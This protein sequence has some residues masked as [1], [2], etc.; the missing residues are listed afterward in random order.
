MARS[1]SAS[2]IF[3]HAD[4]AG[5]LCRAAP[6]YLDEREGQP[7]PRGEPLPTSRA[8]DHYCRVSVVILSNRH[9][10][11]VGCWWRWSSPLGRKADDSWWKFHSSYNLEVQ[12]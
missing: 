3:Q 6:D 9:G 1:R 10:L 11:G 5:A 7:A 2:I 12:R 4:K 8:N